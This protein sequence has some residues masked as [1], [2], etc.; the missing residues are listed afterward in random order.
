MNGTDIVGYGMEGEV[1]CV[2]CAIDIFANV[3][4]CEKDD[5]GL[6]AENCSGQGPNPIFAVDDAAIDNCCECGCELMDV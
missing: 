5:N 3:C 6:C 1:F 2:D 4:D